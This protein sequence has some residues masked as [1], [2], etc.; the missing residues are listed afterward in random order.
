[1]RARSWVAIVLGAVL[2]GGGACSLGLYLWARAFFAQPQAASDEV[3]TWTD[4]Y[5]VLDTKSSRG[6]R[7]VLVR[8]WTTVP[9]LMQRVDLY[10][11]DG[12]HMMADATRADFTRSRQVLSENLDDQ[13][14]RAAAGYTARWP[15]RGAVDLA[16]KRITIEFDAGAPQVIAIPE[17]AVRARC[18]ASSAQAGTP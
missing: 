13:F 17:D 10:C 18:A 9:D 4:R 3:L 16:K 7:Y 14:R 8:V 15:K 5:E 1:M 6:Y 11:Y 2:A 12:R